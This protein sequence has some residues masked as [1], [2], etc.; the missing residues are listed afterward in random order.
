M[1]QG[2]PYRQY[3][4]HTGAKGIERGLPPEARGDGLLPYTKAIDMWYY[5]DL[6]VSTG[7]M[8]RRAGS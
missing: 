6:L 2:E 1:R 3:V 5:G 8:D 7:M 4:L